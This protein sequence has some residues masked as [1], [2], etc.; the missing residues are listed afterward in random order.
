MTP[1]VLGSAVTFAYSPTLTLA[2][3]SVVDGVTSNLNPVI[4]AT[5]ATPVSGLVIGDFVVSGATATSL[6]PASASAGPWSAYHLTVSL[7]G[8][9]NIDVSLPAG[10]GA[11]DPPSQASTMLFQ[12]APGVTLQWS[13]GLTD[14]SATSLTGVVL[15]IDF[16]SPVTGV[17]APDITLVGASAGSL[18]QTGPTTYELPV[19][20]GPSANVNA[21]VPPGSGSIEPPNMASSYL[22]LLYVKP[23]LSCARGFQL[24]MTPHVCGPPSTGTNQAWS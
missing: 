8:V 16:Q 22:T 7:D 10:S 4:T 11:V 14:G 21:H 2:C 19:T 13:H 12:Y 17:A 5:F 15:G 18:S 1:P 3:D 9:R 6:A 20:L 24:S 23:G